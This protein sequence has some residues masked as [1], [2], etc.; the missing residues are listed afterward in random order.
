MDVMAVPS[1]DPGDFLLAKWAK[2]VLL[3][4][5]VREPSSSFQGVH[6]VNVQAFFIVAFPFWVVGVCFSL[7]FDVSFDWHACGLREIVF[8]TLYLSIENPVVSPDRL[9]VFLRGPFVG[10]LRVSSFDPLS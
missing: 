10:F 7:D 8:P 1:C 6:H 5:E 4:P 2:S 3:L 9:E